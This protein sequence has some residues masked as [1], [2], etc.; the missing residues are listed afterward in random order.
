M[1]DTAKSF[2]TECLTIDPTSRPTAAEA[3]RHPWLAAEK[4]YFVPD[5]E[6]P[7]GRPTDL[8]PHIQRAF[9]AKKTCAYFW[10]LPRGVFVVLRRFADCCSSSCRADLCLCACV[11]FASPGCVN[12]ETC[13][14]QSGVFDDRD[15][16]HVD[17]CWV[18]AARAGAWRGHP[19]VQGG[20][21]EGAG[22]RGACFFVLFWSLFLSIAL[23]VSSHPSIIP[24]P[25]LHVPFPCVLDGHGRAEGAETGLGIGDWVN[26][27]R[28]RS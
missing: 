11:P 6:S 2:V 7:S 13:S 23:L 9:D 17:A 26:E 15:E 25:S 18:L 16:A 5:P 21:R 4:P 1:S 10:F 12:R 8:L 3:L 19:A 20:V 22:R 27:R 28:E 24:P 14:P